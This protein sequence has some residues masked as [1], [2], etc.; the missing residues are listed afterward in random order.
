MPIPSPKKSELTNDQGKSDFVSRCM[1]DATMNEDY[2][3]QKQRAAICYYQYKKAKT[4]STK[5]SLA[6]E[7]NSDAVTNALV[8]IK[9]DSFKESEKYE[10]SPELAATYLDKNGLKN[11]SKWFLAINPN[12]DTQCAARYVHPITSDFKNVDISALERVMEVAASL[13]DKDLANKASDLLTI[14][15]KKKNGENIS[16]FNFFVNERH[17]VLEASI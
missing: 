7:I 10:E 13:N 11:Y 15:L 8:K 1:G 3:D 9:T 12:E 6:L 16:K 2:P 14:A 5:G 17:S 4:K